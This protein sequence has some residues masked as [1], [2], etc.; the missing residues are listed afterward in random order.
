MTTSHQTPDVH[1]KNV[2]LMPPDLPWLLVTHLKVMINKAGVQPEWATTLE[3]TM[4][5]ATRRH[6]HATKTLPQSESKQQMVEAPKEQLK[7][8]EGPATKPPYNLQSGAQTKS[9]TEH[10]NPIV[11]DHKYYP[12]IP[13][14]HG[15]QVQPRQPD[16]HS[17]RR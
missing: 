13:N 17:Q 5:K 6:Q 7:I 4:Q 9:H 1:C 10:N 8:V 15:R 12:R 14:N 16:L 2:S 3:A 11:G